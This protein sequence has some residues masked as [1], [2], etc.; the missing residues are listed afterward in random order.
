MNTILL[1]DG[2]NGHVVECYTDPVEIKDGVAKLRVVGSLYEFALCRTEQLSKVTEVEPCAFCGVR[3]TFGFPYE[4]GVNWVHLCKP[5]NPNGERWMKEAHN[6]EAFEAAVTDWKL[7][8]Q[9]TR[10]LIT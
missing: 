3:P 7:F 8:N 9:E 2:Y 5:G 4:C 6:F 1:P 10:R